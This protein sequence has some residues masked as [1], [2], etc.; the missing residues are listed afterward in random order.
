M[1][2][3]SQGEALAALPLPAGWE[4]KTYTHKQGSVCILQARKPAD[5][6][7]IPLKASGWQEIRLGICCPLDGQQVDRVPDV[8]ERLQETALPTHR[9]VVVVVA[10]DALGVR[11]GWVGEVGQDAGCQALGQP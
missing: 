4:R 9:L 11:V 10:V 1:H 7:S 6:L 8:G 5:I 3:L 2:D